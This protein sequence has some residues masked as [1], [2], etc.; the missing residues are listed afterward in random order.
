MEIVNQETKEKIL[1]K[2]AK[3]SDINEY[4]D[5]YELT[6]EKFMEKYGHW[7]IKQK[8]FVE[9]RFYPDTN[10]LDQLKKL[11]SEDKEYYIFP[12]D[13]SK[14]VY[15]DK[16]SILDKLFYDHRQAHVIVSDIKFN[17]I[18]IKNNFNKV[19]GIGDQ[20]KNK[21]GKKIHMTFDNERIMFSSTDS[22]DELERKA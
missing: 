3:H 14:K 8:N 10:G 17:W 20:M 11:L 18:L 9:I 22:K 1:I 15:R 13:Q 16:I 5:I 12:I 21:I 6:F 2:V 4:Y 19:I 7:G